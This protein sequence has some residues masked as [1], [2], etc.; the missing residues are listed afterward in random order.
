MKIDKNNMGTTNCMFELIEWLWL[1][2]VL[3][4]RF[5]VNVFYELLSLFSLSP[6]L[7]CFLL[8]RKG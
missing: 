1:Q 2:E 3:K 5:A 8:Q 6:V 4:S 7:L